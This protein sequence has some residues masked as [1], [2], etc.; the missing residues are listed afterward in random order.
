MLVLFVPLTYACYFAE[1][2]GNPKLDLPGI[3]AKAGDLHPGGNMEGKDLRF[4]IASSAI[5]ATATTAASNGSVNCMHDSFTPL[6]GLVLF[7]NMHLGEII[8]GGVGTGLYG[9]IVFILVAVFLFGLMA[10]RTPQAT[11]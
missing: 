8:F 2:V 7:I 9:M 5:W 10:G 3:D 11:L 4:G 1:Q 6:A